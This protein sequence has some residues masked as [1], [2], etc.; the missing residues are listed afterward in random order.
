VERLVLLGTG[1]IGGPM[2]RKL[3]GVGNDIALWNRAEQKALLLEADGAG[4]AATL[5]GAARDAEIV[6]LYA[7]AT[8]AGART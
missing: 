5:A 7:F 2:T 6:A 8:S 1:I 4:V 3:V